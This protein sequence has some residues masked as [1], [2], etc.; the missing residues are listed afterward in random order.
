MHRVSKYRHSLKHCT[1]NGNRGTILD[2]IC[3]VWRRQNALAQL[4]PFTRHLYVSPSM[5][6]VVRMSFLGLIAVFLLSGC[7]RSPTP[8]KSSGVSDPEVAPKAQLE[9]DGKLFTLLSPDDTAVRF[10]NPID[11]SHPMKRLYWNGYACGG[12]AIGDFD[13]N[14]LKD[15]FFTSG[16]GPNKIFLQEPS[17]RFKDVTAQAGVDGGDAW[18]AG[19]AVVDIDGD[20]DLDIYVCNYDSPNQLFLNDGSGRFREG[21]TAAGLDLNDASFVPAFADFDKD[22]DLDVYVALNRLMLEKGRPVQPPVERRPDGTLAIQPAYEKNLRLIT[23]NPADPPMVWETGR[24]DRLYRND[25]PGED[26]VP[27]FSDQSA[28]AGIRDHHHALSC[29]W[30]DPNNDGYPDMFVAND[31]LEP[32]LFY[33]NNRNGTFRNVI[34]SAMGHT[35]WFAMGSDE[36]DVNNDG[37]LDLIVL[38]MAATSH[39]RQKV[40]MGSMDRFKWTMD[41]GEPRQ[42]MR[43]VLHVNSGKGRYLHMEHLAGIANSDWSWTPIFADFDLDGWNDLFITNGVARDFTNSDYDFAD[44]HRV[45]RV[46][47]DFF[48]NKPPQPEKNLVYQNLG[49]FHFTD[50]SAD[51]GL[52]ELSMDYSAAAGD[53]DNDGDLDLVV[54]ALDQNVS[55]FRN[56]AVGHQENHHFLTVQLIDNPPNTAAIG[57]EI[58]IQH[59]TGILVR[60]VNPHRGF[61]SSQDTDLHFGLG[62]HNKIEAITIVWPDGQR[63]ILPAPPLDRRI[64][65]HRND[66]RLKPAPAKQK[67]PALFRSYPV[68]TSLAHR[69]SPHDDFARQPLLPNKYSQLGPAV[70]WGDLDGDGKDDVFLGGSAGFPGRVLISQGADQPPEQR[71]RFASLPALAGD[72]RHEDMGALWFDADGDEDV[73]LYVASGSYEFE[74]GDPQLRDRLYINDGTG[75]LARA[76]EGVLPDVAEASG[77]IAAADFDRDGDLDLFVG[78]RLIPGDWPAPASSYLL[79]NQS[80][81]GSP[82]FR[83]ADENIAP[84]LS[85]VGL[86]TAAV[87]TDYDNDSHLD[88][89]LT[90]EWGSV[91]LFR[92]ESGVLRDATSD[93]G[94]DAFAGWWNSI[95]V[96]DLDG[97]GHVDLIAGNMGLNTKYH[98]SAMLYYGDYDGSGRPKCVEAKWERDVLYPLRGRSC[99]SQAMP[100]LGNKFPTYHAFAQATLKEIYSDTQLDTSQRFTANTLATGV[101]WNNGDG[102]FSF[103]ALPTLAQCSPVFGLA[104]LDV[105][106]D[107]RLDL[108][109]AQNFHGPQRETVRYD[110]GVGVTLLNRGNREFE[111]LWP[112]ASGLFIPGDATALTVANLNGDPWPDLL[113]AENNGPLRAFTQNPPTAPSPRLVMW[114]AN[115]TPAMKAGARILDEQGRIL[116]EVHL[117][118]GYLSQKPDWLI[119]PGKTNEV[120]IRWADG[121]VE[122][123]K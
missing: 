71:F 45:Q 16:P 65:L 37:L 73:D 80:A 9:T 117:G 11:N 109:M 2:A 43:N 18:A 5:S 46:E 81:P 122:E 55:I 120:S 20:T 39:Y 116:T 58:S 75:R 77:P 102:T 41:N 89:A 115:A 14:G 90:R 3:H 10:V 23:F 28:S 1:T 68:P 29:L 8:S 85:G 33:A 25:G 101:F 93:A 36:G 38:D 83:T 13:G 95:E 6:F 82:E 114:P 44:E 74:R 78:T 123:V 119:V 69:E 113:V 17:W 66:P 118:S 79:I 94:L 12:V 111:S 70:A 49:D 30:T 99:S 56:N 35:A 87:W 50:R 97:D 7:D 19:A 15:L 112:D 84:G 27:R 100:H 121:T 64:I 110:N 51:W 98:D 53:L 62:A 103:A 4:D 88:L 21:A 92:N 67:P 47:W 105:N 61:L 104:P 72:A 107:G 42:A 48:E 54:A 52:D 108:V 60:R 32:D 76:P 40:T 31:Y 24:S 22:G 86:V 57:A 34:R 91:A 106:G 59:P 96:A 63:Q 26:G